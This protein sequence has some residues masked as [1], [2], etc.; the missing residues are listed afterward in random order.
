MRRCVSSTVV[1][2]FFS[3][4]CVHWGRRVLFH[5]TGGEARFLRQFIQ[6]KLCLTQTKEMHLGL[7]KFVLEVETL[8]NEFQLS[9]RGDHISHSLQ[10]AVS[11]FVLQL[12]HT[13][14]I[15]YVALEVFIVIHQFVELH[16]RPFNFC[17]KR[18]Q[19]LLMLLHGVFN[20]RF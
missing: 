4:D 14:L 12:H 5:N 10:V 20:T 1:V 3:F 11:D 9:E 15:D 6:S 17:V 16:E 2:Y 7:V 18:V 13:L 19:V 8:L